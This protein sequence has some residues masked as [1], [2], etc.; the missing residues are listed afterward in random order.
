MKMKV[1]R[2]AKMIAIVSAHFGGE[3]GTVT[4]PP[5]TLEPHTMYYMNLMV[6]GGT[7]PPSR[8]NPGFL[9]PNKLWL[10]EDIVTPEGIV[11]RKLRKVILAICNTG[12]KDFTLNEGI[13]VEGSMV[14]DSLKGDVNIPLHRNMK[15]QVAS[16]TD[17]KV[18]KQTFEK[19]NTLCE[20][21][22]SDNKG[23][24]ATSQMNSFTSAPNNLDPPN[25][26]DSNLKDLS[27]D[28]RRQ[29]LVDLQLTDNDYLIEE[30]GR[31]VLR[32][33]S[34]ICY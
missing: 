34:K 19:V 10:A 13:K 1:Q 25:T 17:S 2:R 8:K 21:L 6:E 11:S 14:S 15:L 16:K 5:L 32:G 28:A 7:E 33:S 20:M 26:S 4:L 9:I 30:G 27:G 31:W 18:T 12:D 23:A 22:K 29:L 24:K 3:V